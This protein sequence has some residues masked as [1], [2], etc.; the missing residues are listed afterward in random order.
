MKS[1]NLVL[2]GVVLGLICG[3]KSQVLQSFTS[4]DPAS[5]MS[6]P[7]KVMAGGHFD[8]RTRLGSVNNSSLVS[9][10]FDSQESRRV[11]P[12]D[13]RQSAQ[14]ADLMNRAVAAEDDK[15]LDDARAIYN[16][17]LRID[18]GH[19]DAHHRLAV[20]ADQQRDFRTAERHYRAALTAGKPSANLLSDVGYSFLL[21]KRYRESETALIAA[22]N[23]DRE[24]RQATD[25]LGQLYRLQGDYQAAERVFRRFR[26]DEEADSLLAR[27]F[28]NGNPQPAVLARRGTETPEPYGAIQAPRPTREPSNSPHIIPG[29][30]GPNAL[31][32]QIHERM[33]EARERSI[34]QRLRQQ[35]QPRRTTDAREVARTVSR[36]P[37]YRERESESG[38]PY[39]PRGGNSLRR[40]TQPQNG[41]PADTSRI[42]A[43][44]RSPV[45]PAENLRSP[46]VS[47][48]DKY[49][50]LGRTIP[51]G[52]INE[53]FE[54]IDRPR[55][56]HTRPAYAGAENWRVAAYDGRRAANAG[57]RGSAATHR[58]PLAPTPDRLQR[59]TPPRD[60]TTWGP[61]SGLRRG[62]NIESGRSPRSG[63]WP[64]NGK[65]APRDDSRYEQ[66]R[67]IEPLRQET[68]T[69]RSQ[70][71]APAGNQARLKPIAT[72]IDPA[73]REALQMARN[74]G[75]GGPMFAA[76][77][78]RGRLQLDHSRQELNAP[79]DSRTAAAPRYSNADLRR[80][81]DATD[82]RG[83]TQRYP[84]ASRERD[85]GE[86]M[87]RLD[88]RDRSAEPAS[89]RR[90]PAGTRYRYE[91]ERYYGERRR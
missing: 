52:K 5:D 42:A 83:S 40:D 50:Q 3:C 25:N 79:R 87:R 68:S 63:L 31:T 8:E 72:P 58:R 21:Q 69:Y 16:Q 26:T 82:D 18:S 47:E 66:R 28:P 43:R 30:P 67:A 41:R 34:Q 88:P 33:K 17:V 85:A 62:E 45:R 19:G 13:P 65:A 71:N 35:R 55:S 54:D 46:G 51:T 90:E 61:E 56:G 49:R 76:P 36:D 23:A 81:Y 75:F 37:R 10:L 74:V 73:S 70:D 27:F 77:Q 7:A 89:L 64:Q 60:S 12:K 9:R 44:P 11:P 6:D 80:T 84:V 91:D 38:Y 1:R 48:Y 29:T 20:I 2:S 4:P 24:H 53:V 14:L 15:R 57:D 86:G 39:Q 32:Q 22:L 59:P 78:D